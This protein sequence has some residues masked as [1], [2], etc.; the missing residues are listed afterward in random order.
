MQ[1]K[2]IGQ[3]TPDVSAF[4]LTRTLFKVFKDRLY[5]SSVKA[6]VSKLFI[7]DPDSNYFRLCGP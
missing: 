3:Q 1:V 2:H 5:H 4:S 7:K 6:R